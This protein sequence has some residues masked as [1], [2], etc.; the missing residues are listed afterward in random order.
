ME[1]ERQSL[2]L[3]S[4]PAMSRHRGVKALAGVQQLFR[5]GLVP[6]DVSGGIAA[7][8]AMQSGDRQTRLAEDGIHAL[9]RPAAYQRKRSAGSVVQIANERVKIVLEP[10]LRWRGRKIRERAVDVEEE[11]P[12][13]I[14]RGNASRPRGTGS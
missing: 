1:G 9:D 14:R 11:C 7:L 3:Q 4:D 10:H 5:G 8:E 6:A 13:R 12:P 2:V